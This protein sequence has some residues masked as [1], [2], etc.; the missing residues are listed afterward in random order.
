MKAIKVVQYGL[1]PIGLGIVDVL[2]S[3]PWAQLVG[4]IDID[5]SKVGKDVGDLLV[6]PRKTGIVVKDK[7][8]SVLGREET[9]I[10]T[11]STS[12]YMKTVHPQ[13]VEILEHGASVISTA[14]ELSYPFVKHPDVARE[15]DTLARRKKR[16]FL[17]VE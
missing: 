16:S 5:R 7:L 17:V 4:A 1:G 9:D 11:H 3:R 15:L 10:V 12:S 14:E 8:S 2:L 6:T 13:L